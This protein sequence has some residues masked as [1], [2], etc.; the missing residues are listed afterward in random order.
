MN[1]NVFHFLLDRICS[2]LTEEARTIGFKKALVFENRV[3]EITQIE[4]DKLDNDIAAQHGALAEYAQEFPLSITVDMNP[5]AQAFPDIVLG[6][7]GIEVKFTEAD[8]W[9]CIANSV[10]ETNKVHSVKHICVVY[11]KMGGIPE[12]R[13]DDWEHAVMHVRTSHVPRFE[14][15]IGSDRSLFNIMGISYDDFSALEMSE[16][17]VYIRNYARSRLKEGEHLWWLDDPSD[18]SGSSHALPLNAR[19]YTNLDMEE[20][21]RMRAEAVLL[22]PQILSSG[23]SRHKYDDLVMFMLTYHG[24]LCHQARDL[25]S[26]GSAAGVGGNGRIKETKMEDQLEG[27][28]FD[29]IYIL[30][31][32]L[33][34]EDYMIKAANTLED[35]LF[36]EYWGDEACAAFDI[37]DPKARI[38]YWLERADYFA[39]EWKPSDYLFLDQPR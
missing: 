19:L 14:L 21:N 2:V 4:A 30:R 15:E 8:T 27:K 13:Y 6:D 1:I 28:E 37:H 35:K 16:K 11:C 3:R 5:P 26:A 32:L 24:V 17:M 9:R 36:I 20:K 33:H 7:V 10:L 29:G 34:L 39:K 38:K 22:C 12:V 31:A 23:R 25:F 18:D